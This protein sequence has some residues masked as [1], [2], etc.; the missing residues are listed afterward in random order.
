[1]EVTEAIRT[2][3]EIREYADEAVDAEVI[4]TILDAGRLAPSGK[5]LQHW[6]FVVVRESEDI[7]KLASLSTTG[8]WVR[9]AAFAVVIATDP[10]YDYH[11]I[12]AGRAVTHMQLA[13]WEE[14]IGSCIYTGYD[15]SEMRDFLDIPD[16]QA[17]T[18]V[19][20]FGYPTEPVESF[21][22]RK[23]RASLSEVV[24]DRRYGEPW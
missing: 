5:N 24:H 22:G 12:D 8:G 17:I 15:E 7:A 13:A 6:D 2:R 19:A 4:E 10:T 16:S 3:L 21:V 14:G 9:K 23:D 20:G 18:L 11:E 1:M